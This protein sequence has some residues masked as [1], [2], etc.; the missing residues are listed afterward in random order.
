MSAATIKKTPVFEI[1]AN[2]DAT[3]YAAKLSGHEGFVVRTSSRVEYTRIIFA[4]PYGM[5]N[6]EGLAARLDRA[7]REINR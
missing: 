3:E 7:I 5:E 6:V 2:E 1:W 4:V